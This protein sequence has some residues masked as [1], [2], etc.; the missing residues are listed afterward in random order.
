LL[1][2]A[3]IIA[4]V[5]GL[6]GSAAAFVPTADQ[7][8]CA[9]VPANADVVTA[10]TRIIDAP[11]SSSLDRAVSYTFRADASRADGNWP[12]LSPITARRWR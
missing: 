4:F 12:R 2:A 9:T 6:F 7:K 11:D 8:A 3:C 1:R 5:G 10:C